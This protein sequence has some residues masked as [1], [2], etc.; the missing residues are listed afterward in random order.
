MK[1]HRLAALRSSSTPQAVVCTV[2]FQAHGG[3]LALVREVGEGRAL[4]KVTRMRCYSSPRNMETG[5]VKSFGGE[6]HVENGVGE[7]SLL[8]YAE[9]TA[10]VPGG[11]IK[12]ALAF[13]QAVRRDF[14]QVIIQ[15][16]DDVAAACRSEHVTLGMAGSQC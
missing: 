3:T 1:N 2:S 13:T 11:K 14:M 10:E 8:Q 12:D 16:D 7:E 5:I 15:Q 9:F 4:F 6:A